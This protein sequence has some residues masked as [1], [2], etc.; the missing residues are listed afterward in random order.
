MCN[1]LY[2]PF[3]AF[4]LSGIQ[5][6]PQTSE[7]R[8]HVFSLLGYAISQPRLI[9]PPLITD[10]PKQLDPSKTLDTRSSKDTHLLLLVNS[11]HH[12]ARLLGQLAL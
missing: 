12:L 10:R 1:Q 9:S 2:D 3:S 5:P 6:V 4:A 7:F 11:L 8:R